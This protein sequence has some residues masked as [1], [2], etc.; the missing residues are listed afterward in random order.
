MRNVAGR[1]GA[2]HPDGA[3]RRRWIRLGRNGSD[4]LIDNTEGKNCR[5]LSPTKLEILFAAFTI[6]SQADPRL[7]G[8]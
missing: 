7:A 5:H 4:I 3:G 6:V 8:N 2:R 1:S